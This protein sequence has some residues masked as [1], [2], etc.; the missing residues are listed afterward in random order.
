MGH[1]GAYNVR[2]I[3]QHVNPPPSRLAILAGFGVLVIAVTAAHWPVLSAG[4]LSLDDSEFLTN[5]RLVQSP[6]W[7]STQTFLTEVLEPSTVRGY[8]LPLSMMS[9]MGDYAMGGRPD[10]LAPFHRTSLILHVINCVLLTVLLGWL[11]GWSLPVF[12]VG[13]L[14]GLHPLTVEPVVWVGER[15]TLLAA[16]F[17]LLAMLAYVRHTRVGGWRWMMAAT[18]AYTLAMMS[19]PTAVMLP[20]LLVLMDWWPLGRLTKRSL[21]EK[22]PL[23]GI[24]V[25]FSVIALMSHDRTAGFLSEESPVSVNRVLLALYLCGFYASKILWPVDLT[26]IYA[27]PNP[28]SITH[29]LVILGI[30][31][32]GGFGLLIWAT[33]KRSRAIA[34]GVLFF[35]LALAPTMGV[36]RY[37]WVTASDKYV[38]LPAFGLAML[39]A[40]GLALLWT[41]LNRQ[42]RFALI[43]VIAAV[44]GLE[45]AGT[46]VAAS[47][48]RDTESHFRYLTVNAPGHPM[49]HYGLGQCLHRQERYAEAIEQYEQVL[50]IAP[51]YAE[52]HHDLAVC[53]FEQG[54]VDR[55]I[56]RY[57]RAIEI[58]SD[59]SEFHRSLGVALEAVGDLSG[60]MKSLN[61]AIELDPENAHA[62]SDLAK[63]LY[64]RGDLAAAIKGFRSALQLDPKS[65]IARNGLGVVLAD[66]GDIDASIDEFL[67]CLQSEPANAEVHNSLA[68]SYLKKRDFENA[69]THY[70]R[71]V[72]ADPNYAVA[73]HNLA[74]LL[75]SLKRMDEAIEHHLEAIRCEPN[76]LEARMNLANIFAGQQRFREAEAQLRKAIESYPDAP[77]AYNNLATILRWQDRIDEAADVYANV[78]R[79]MP[80]DAD[81][82]Y[83][84]GKL[85]LRLKDQDAAVRYFKKALEIN[86]EHERAQAE[87]NSLSE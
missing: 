7:A 29:P 60:A 82:Q 10:N 69:L 40:W 56:E 11:F 77:A 43:G 18:L 39:A 57:R 73:H 36:V 35:G 85:H 87:L 59:E 38:Y 5:N 31:I 49:A 48:W 9:L 16:F 51:N 37:S 32:V 13:L 24:M 46:R 86:P 63:T 30:V 12:A 84:M 53:L 34:G 14:F 68:N 66:T 61:R 8:Y 28:L 71:A 50:S 67:T 6:S 54:A 74:V 80:N 44:L 65:V 21:V 78:V 22:V 47:H 20:L 45:V 42:S 58:K 76:Y 17:V 62:H 52:V 70:R 25:L 26:P 2:M 64:G 79:L 19:K 1:N 75:A 81:A 72:D 4:A 83:T 3:G 15:K 33:S 55:A 23:F 27:M 41:K